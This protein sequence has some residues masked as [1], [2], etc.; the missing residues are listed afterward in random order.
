MGATVQL[1]PPNGTEKLVL[2]NKD[3]IML[4]KELSGKNVYGWQ[5]V[6][7][8]EYGIGT[9]SAHHTLSKNRGK[10]TYGPARDTGSAEGSF[11]R[12]PFVSL[13]SSHQT[14]RIMS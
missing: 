14:R 11:Q 9:G 10:I 6:E 5:R 7:R 12:K 2:I 4:E 8:G 3:V 1:Q 13:L